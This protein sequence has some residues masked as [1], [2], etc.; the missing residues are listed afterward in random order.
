MPAQLRSAT[1]KIRIPNETDD[2]FD[3]VV[4]GSPTPS[5]GEG[6]HVEFHRCAVRV[7]LNDPDL[8]SVV[9]DV[10]VEGDQPRLARLR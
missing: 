3:L 10:L 7:H 9:V 5:L 1:G 2:D 6:L 8:G 4:I